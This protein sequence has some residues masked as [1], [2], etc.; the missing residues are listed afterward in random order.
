M[1]SP[2]QI[3]LA[4]YP[5]AAQPGIIRYFAFIVAAGLLNSLIAA[6]LFLRL[7]ED[8]AP[9]L[10]T[11]VV[12]ASIFVLVGALAGTVGAWYYWRR[13]ASPFLVDPP[14]PFRLFALASAAGWVWVP[15]IV[16]LS[17][18]DSPVTC[19]VAILGAA[20]LATALRQSI[21]LRDLPIPTHSTAPGQHG[22]ELFAATLR[23]PRRE[24]HGY[25]LSIGFYLAGYELS[26]GWILDAC[27]LLA[28]CAFL[29]VWKWTLEPSAAP[30]DKLHS[31]KQTA[32]ATRRLALIL[33]PAVLVT[34]FALLDGVE[35]RNRLE[36]IAAAQSRDNAQP[37]GDDAAQ[38][39]QPDAHPSATGIPGYQ[40]IILWPFPQKKEILPPLPQPASLLA[41]GTTKPL[42]IRFDG[43]YF[44]FQPPHKSP[45]PAALQVRGTPLIH[46][47]Q[48]NNFMPLVM[49]AHQTLGS[50]IPLAR[51]R[52]IQVGILNGDNRPGVINVAV[53]LSH[54]SAPTNQL[55]LGQQ[56]V[57]SSQPANFGFKPTAAAETLRFPVPASGPASAKLRSFDHITV[58]FLPDDANY[59]QGSKV[60]IQQ[61]QLIPR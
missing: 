41:P 61:F 50:A 9:T 58:M 54:S 24:I 29:F 37:Q 26:N 33:V 45:S 53:L 43:P 13:P 59:D 1:A 3:G 49:E 31:R 36:A 10:T 32:R 22:R 40:S 52:E 23:T 16:L 57:V 8:H 35:H 15:A 39:P 46:D 14:I 38:K 28:L 47:F 6:F 2:T 20:L 25:L 56:P 18:E 42:I 48:S 7:P 4:T 12:R 19:A 27:A 44:Y 30:G 55:Y 11:L 60:A 5:A 17:R 51:C 21:P 34:L